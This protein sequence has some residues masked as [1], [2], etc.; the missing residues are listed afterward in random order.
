MVRLDC[1]GQ[2]GL[3]GLTRAAP[4]IDE[5]GWNPCAARALERRGA[6]R[7][8]DDPNNGGIDGRRVGARAV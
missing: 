4:M 7:V 1:C 5:G 2:V 3:K 6:G 8:G